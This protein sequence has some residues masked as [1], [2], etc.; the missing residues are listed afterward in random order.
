AVGEG[1][2]LNLFGYVGA[3]TVAAVA[4]GARHTLT[5]D[6]SKAAIERARESVLRRG[7][8][9]EHRFL[10]EDVFELLPRLA[11]RGERFDHVV[12]D[13]PTHA[14]TK[15]HRFNSGKDWVGLAA[16]CARLV[17]EGGSWWASTNDRRMGPPEF[18]RVL[19]RGA[20]EAGREVTGRRHLEPPLDFPHV[21]G[22]PPHQKMVVLTLR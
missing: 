5:V 7:P 4:G 10:A 8:E 9:G 18:E 17:S 3:F 21:P 2:V 20:S 14:R 12:V 22:S 16:Q 19:R 1:S 15:K 6:A 11:R 13:P